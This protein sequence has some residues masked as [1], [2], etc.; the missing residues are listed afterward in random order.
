MHIYL[1]IDDEK[2]GPFTLYQVE[3]KLR[4]NEIA[5]ETLGWHDGLGNWTPL[6][7]LPP[8][9]GFFRRRDAELEDERRREYAERLAEQEEKEA[10]EAGPPRPWTRFWARTIDIWIFLCFSL[11]I[12]AGLRSLGWTTTSYVYFSERVFILLLPAWHLIEAYMI[13]H[14]AATPGKALL[15]IRVLGQDGEPLS[16]SPSVRRSLGVF[17]IGLGCFLPFLQ[18]ILPIM[19]YFYLKQHGRTFW[20]L[21]SDSKTEHQAFHVRQVVFSLL[22]VFTL[23]SLLRGPLTEIHEHQQELFNGLMNEA[24]PAEVEES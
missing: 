24:K 17:V 22:V 8:F 15:G 2:A 12:L 10:K 1:A 6:R 5:E 20:D 3:E 21:T 9:E 7:E 19:A 13:S 14:W 4:S 11:G 23:A 18:L 16:Y